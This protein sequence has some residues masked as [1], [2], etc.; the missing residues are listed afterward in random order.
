MASDFHEP[1]NCS[2]GW[3]A[4]AM[5]KEAAKIAPAEMEPL[6]ASTAP[7]PSASDWSARRTN[8]VATK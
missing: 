1:I 6:I 3:S 2:I 7:S 5:R 4:R 8:L